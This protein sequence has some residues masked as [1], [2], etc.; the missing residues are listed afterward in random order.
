MNVHKWGYLQA[1]LMTAHLCANQ[2]DKCTHLR[3]KVKVDLQIV[4]VT[5]SQPLMLK[6]DNR[7][8]NSD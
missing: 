3:E 6:G 8:L 5:E 1:Y 4:G 2:V 7:E